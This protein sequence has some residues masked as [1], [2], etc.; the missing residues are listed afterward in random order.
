VTVFSIRGGRRGAVTVSGS[1]WQPGTYTLTPDMRLSDAIAVAGGL[2][3]ETYSGRVQILRTRPDS[4]KVLLGVPLDSGA[5]APADNPSLREGDEVTVFAMTDFRPAQYVTVNG[6][7]NKPGRVA[8]AD[9]MTLRDAILLAGGPGVGAYLG[10]AEV[11]RLNPSPGTNGDSLALIL[12]VPLDSSYLADATTRD[13]TAASASPAVFLQPYDQVFV[14]TRPGWELQR[15]VTLEGEV[16]F[17]GRY[18][19]TSK[20]ERLLTVIQRA[21]GLT[22]NAYANGI[23]FFRANSNTGRLGVDLERVLRDPNYRDNLVLEAGDSVNI[24]R[25][26]PVVRVEGAV[27]APASVT[28]R[29]GADLN[30]YVDAAGGYL[31]RADKGRTYVLQP[32]GQ[33]E[34]RGRPQPGAVVHV[35][36]KENAQ[37]GSTL[38]LILGALA[39]IVSAVTTIIAVLHP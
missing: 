37:R 9:S 16:R 3:P 15:N 1:V 25:Y 27:E 19:L 20:D 30:Y 4:T 18:T 26:S 7:V 36:Q 14:R 12:R 6:A 34:K 28:Y 17:P 39:P 10:E 8:Y 31:D 33:V 29:P 35:P 2:R 24:P 21:G 23:Q 32:N 13:G 11:S 22:P 38:V 5:V